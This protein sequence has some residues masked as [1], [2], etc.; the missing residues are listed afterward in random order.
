M[1]SIEIEFLG[2]VPLYLG[3]GIEV[4]TAMVLGGLIGFDREKKMKAA[5]IKTNMLICIGS[6][7]YTAISFINHDQ[8]GVSD[9]NRIAAQIVSGIGFLGAGAIIQGRGSITGMT[10]AATIWVVAAMGVAIGSG[11]PVIA[12]IFA[13]TILIV[14]KILHPFYKFFEPAK[15]F[16]HYHLQI[17]SKGSIKKNLRNVLDKE[18]VSIEGIREEILDEKKNEHIINVYI[19]A[20][21]RRIKTVSSK[22]KSI[23]QVQKVN[24]N[25]IKESEG[26]E[27]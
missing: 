16:K 5:G 24:Y 10:T 4:L 22:V 21:P 3:L 11:Y 18:V 25:S 27:S 2:R 1:K 13:V 23:V 14:L 15:E 17:L 19:T 26:E 7:L 6:T 20:H 9:P 12:S 8:G